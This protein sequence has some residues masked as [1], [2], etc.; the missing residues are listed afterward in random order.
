[1]NH[2]GS[3]VLRSQSSHCKESHDW[4]NGPSLS[5]H[6]PCSDEL[7]V[8]VTTENK[9]EKAQGSTPTYYCLQV[10]LGRE[11]CHLSTR[12]ESIEEAKQA[13][14]RT[15]AGVARW[16]FVSAHVPGC[17]DEVPRFVL[18]AR[19]HDEG[20]TWKS[21]Q[22]ASPDQAPSVDR[23]KVTI[24]E[25]RMTT[26]LA[27]RLGFFTAEEVVRHM[28]ARFQSADFSDEKQVGELREF[29]RRGLLAYMTPSAAEE[30]AA[31][32]TELG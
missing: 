28:C 32:C 31:K 19:V 20:V 24:Q 7:G 5:W 13:F 25:Q 29:L 23:P 26:I 6:Q 3:P 21:L 4:N 17:D 22:R 30:L 2:Q 12:Y 18:Q 27:P 9:T 14:E 11:L 15:R 1:M 8:E 16:C 10:P